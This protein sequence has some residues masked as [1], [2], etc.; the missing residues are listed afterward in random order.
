MK[1]KDLHIDGF[2]VWTDLA[3]DSLPDSMTLFYGPNEAGKTTVMQ[4][5]RSMLYGFTP[6]R[7]EKYLP[8]IY[9]GTPGGAIRVTGPGG[10][11][12]IRRH[13]KMTDQNVIGQLTVTGKDGL[14]QGHHRLSML[15]GQIDEPIFTNVF[16]IGMRELQELN[17]LDDTAAADELYKLSSGL[18][19][20]SLVDVIRSLQDGRKSL[21]GQSAKQAGA[22]ADKLDR[23]IR[24]RE[25]LRDEVNQLTGQ[26]RRWAELATLRQSQQQEIKQ[27]RQRISDTEHETRRIEAAISVFD[28]WTERQSMQSQIEQIEAETHLP[29]EAPGQLVQIEAMLEERR[30]KLEDVKNKRRSLREK[31][32][33]IP[34]S[35]Q[36]LD[37][38]GKIEAATEQ[39][40]WVEALEEQIEKV[41]S[42]I[43]SARNQLGTD[44]ERLGLDEA[45]RELLLSGDASKMPDLSRE[46]LSALSGPAKRVKE[47]LFLLK[48]ARSEGAEHKKRMEHFD[49][50]LSEVLQRSRAN[51]LQQAIREENQHLASLRRAAQLGEHIEK[52]KRHYRSLENESVDLSASEVLPIDSLLLM[53]LPFVV[54]GCCIIVALSHFLGVTW[55]LVGE[56]SPTTG[57]VWM[58]IGV[59]LMLLYFMSKQNNHRSTASDREDCDR[60]IEL[61]KKQIRELEAEEDD[62]EAELPGSSQPIEFRVR[63]AELLLADLEA[64]MPAYHSHAAA[65]HA[66]EASRAKAVK[67]AENLKTARRAW[68]STLRQLGLAESL[69]PRSV[70]KLSEGYETLQGSLRRLETLC[71][72]R[73]QRERE[74]QNLAKRIEALYIESLEINEQDRRSASESDHSSEESSSHEAQLES[75]MLRAS[76]VGP[77]EQ[78]NHLQ[79]EIS[80]QQHWI[81][82]RRDLKDQDAQLKRQH[83]AYTRSIQRGEQQ[84][85]ALW[86][87]C[88]VAT[89]EQFYAMVDSKASLVELREQHASIDQQIRS[90]IGANLGFDA[91]TAEI[92][93]ASQQDLERRWELL[94]TR[95]T[96]MQQRIETLQTQLGESAADMK[97]LAEDNRLMVTQLELGCVNRKIENIARRWQTMATASCLVEEVCGKF[98]RERQPETLREASS[99]LSQLT[100][101]KYVRIWTP[102]GT[103]Q[104]KIDN[105]SGK[106]LPLEVLS[107]GTREA[108]FIALRL[109][110]AAAYARR[111]VMLPLILDDVLVNFD[112]ERALHAAETLQTFAQLGHQVMMFT[113]HEHI[114][115]IFHSIGVEVRQLPAQGQPGRATILLP[116]E[117]IEEDYETEEVVDYVEEQVIEEPEYEPEEEPQEQAVEE[118]VVAEP[119]P[120]PQQEQPARAGPG[121]RTRACRGS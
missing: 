25:Q 15:L 63:Q 21:I 93:G 92:D 77:L 27:L 100:D 118:T 34:V 39:A 64:T 9:G 90:M 13:A 51:D 55:F 10:G 120:E 12:R 28:Q 41:D 71:N 8:P 95:M 52:L 57:M 31:A 84:R 37:L 45:D 99:F 96:E 32:S 72:E 53:G 46:T 117:D 49:E 26:S 97:H 110:L 70:R 74:R 73:N 98:E 35:A 121:T 113:C 33:Q 62:V 69:S 102:L 22:D 86:A 2:G 58:L 104:L 17:T 78:L 59:M 119:Q 50:E 4:F 5:L 107:R 112:G 111:G 85:R 80:R 6:D 82:R 75:N 20:V 109:S 116:E 115:D 61:L 54:G 83:A 30:G 29:D 76:K 43:Q 48:Q 44:A 67:A 87:K 114:V 101:G 7:R 88:G 3:V 65:K 1:V 60:Q 19:R 24:R 38:Q 47:H 36:M 16:A 42:Q 56:A 18:D 14:A 40:T 81:K 23:L 106:A 68:T 108:V 94:S 103:N 11:Y 79:E 89:A 91:V 66:Y 105:H